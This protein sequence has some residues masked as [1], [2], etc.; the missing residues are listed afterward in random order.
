MTLGIPSI[1]LRS[2]SRPCFR[3]LQFI[4]RDG[5]VEGHADF[6]SHDMVRAW[7]LNMIGIARLVARMAKDLGLKP[8][9]ITVSSKSAHFYWRD[10]GYMRAQIRR[11]KKAQGIIEKVRWGFDKRCGRGKRP[12]YAAGACVAYGAPG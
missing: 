4:V 8:G 10:L 11:Y 12:D 1:D 6:R 3:E 2:D 9:L 7:K 5:V